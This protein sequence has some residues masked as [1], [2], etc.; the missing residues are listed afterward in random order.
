[1]PLNLSNFVVSIDYD[2][3]MI[4]SANLWVLLLL[5]CDNCFLPVAAEAIRHIPVP[6]EGGEMCVCMLQ[7]N[8]QTLVT[9]SKNYHDCCMRQ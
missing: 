2:P 9:V 4:I 1:M 8:R 3:F 7:L 5:A 6:G